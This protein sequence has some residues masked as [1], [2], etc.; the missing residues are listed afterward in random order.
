[1][2]DQGYARRCIPVHVGLAPVPSPALIALI[3]L[4]L[5]RRITAIMNPDEIAARLYERR[6]DA[7]DVDHTSVTIGDWCPDWNEC[8][9]N[10]DRWCAEHPNCRAVR[11][12]LLVPR[13]TIV[14]FY[15]HSV[16]ANEDGTLTDITP[17]V[18]PHKYPFLRHDEADGA[19]CQFKKLGSVLHRFF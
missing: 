7:V 8:H 12:W 1:M 18:T 3:S 5:A 15:A 10:V 6:Y 19:F 16:I 13:G 14:Q 17:R 9:L 2:P 11:G 4:I